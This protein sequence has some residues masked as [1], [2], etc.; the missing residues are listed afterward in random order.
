MYENLIFDYIHYIKKKEAKTGD[1]YSS[2]SQKTLIITK[3]V[4]H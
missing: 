1:R 2:E 3:I 4:L